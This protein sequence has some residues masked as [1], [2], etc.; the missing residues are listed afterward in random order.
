M[1]GHAIDGSALLLV[2]VHAEF[3]RMFHGARCD[4]HVSNITVAGL[5]LDLRTNVRSVIKSNM[6]LFGPPKN[7]LPW[8]VLAFVVVG[9]KLL[10]LGVFGKRRLV[11]A[12]AGSD[13]GN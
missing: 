2:A 11:A 1:T 12:P 6:R 7:T 8:N 3:H 4:S 5:T 9:S 13:I 10:D